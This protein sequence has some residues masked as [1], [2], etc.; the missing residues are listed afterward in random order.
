M[1][2]SLKN[3]SVTLLAIAQTRLGLLGNELQAQKILLVQLL[4]LLLALTFCAGLAI[5]LGLGLVVSVWW[6][7][8]VLVLGLSAVIFVALALFCFLRL[9]SLLNPAETAFDASL[10]ALKDDMAMLRAAT[11]NSQPPADQKQTG[12]AGE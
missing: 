6:E 11:Q 4:G 12:S 5:L 9:Q 8:R 10:A 7:Q 1:L 3:L 2:S